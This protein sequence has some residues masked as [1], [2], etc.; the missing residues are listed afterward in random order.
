MT[1][2]RSP[3]AP[4]LVVARRGRRPRGR[5]SGSRSGV[6]PDRVARQKNPVAARPPYAASE[7]ARELHRE[8]LVV[9]LHA[10]SLLWGRDLLVRARHGHVDVPRLVE[11]GIALEVMAVCTQ[12]AAPGRT[13]SATTTGPTT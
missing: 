2:R 6:V 9:D 7:R 1:E 8:L 4:A 3:S 13:S 12:V 5:R 11:G 10:D